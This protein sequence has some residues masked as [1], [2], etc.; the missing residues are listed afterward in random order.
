MH[1]RGVIKGI[2]SRIVDM[3]IRIQII[4]SQFDC[5]KI[6]KVYT[7]FIFKRVRSGHRANSSCIGRRVGKYFRFLVPDNWYIVAG[8]LKWKLMRSVREYFIDP[9]A[10]LSSIE[11]RQFKFL[12]LKEISSMVFASPSICTR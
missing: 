10:E 1:D 8:W 7:S 5:I 12:K 4:P 9:L 2:E 3:P 6:F 11:S